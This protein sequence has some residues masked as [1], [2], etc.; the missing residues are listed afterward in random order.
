MSHVLHGLGARVWCAYLVW[1]V[2]CNST[3]L[4]AHP[5]SPHSPIPSPARRSCAWS[6][7]SACFNL[8]VPIHDL[9]AGTG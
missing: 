8:A 1:G 5:L 3:P 4:R 2:S 9:S 7:G 6:D